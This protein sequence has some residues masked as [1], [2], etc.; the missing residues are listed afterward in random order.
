MSS[1]IHS[2]LIF[3]VIYQQTT[4]LSQRRHHIS[5]NA[6]EL[7]IYRPNL[8]SRRF[9]YGICSIDHFRCNEY[10]PIICLD[11]SDCTTEHRRL[12]ILVT[13]DNGFSVHLICQRFCIKLE[14]HMYNHFG[15]V[16]LWFCELWTISILFQIFKL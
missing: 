3:P 2:V 16:V 1:T 4:A 9:K 10:W 5:F 6:T 8:H 14:K 11:P 13:W 12:N 15:K 7:A